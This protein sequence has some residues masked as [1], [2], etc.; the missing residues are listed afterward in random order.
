MNKKI[1][2]IIDDLDRVSSEEKMEEILSFVGEVNYDFGE[3]IRLIT[4]GSK[5]KIKKIL[6]NQ[7]EIG[8]N[9]LDKYFEK[10]LHLTEISLKKKIDFF[11]ENGRLNEK[12]NVEKFINPELMEYD[13]INDESFEEA[14]RVLNLRSGETVEE[15]YRELGMFKAKYS[16]RNIE[17]FLKDLEQEKPITEN[18]KFYNK[19]HFYLKYFYFFYPEYYSFLYEK[20]E[21]LL[22]MAERNY[23]ERDYSN[24]NYNF[25]EILLGSATNFFI[26]LLAES[27]GI[28]NERVKIIEQLEEKLLNIND[29]EDFE[30]KFYINI[31]D[32]FGIKYKI[33]EKGIILSKIIKNRKIAEFEKIELLNLFKINVSIKYKDLDELKNEMITNQVIKQGVKREFYPIRNEIMEFIDLNLIF[34]LNFNNKKQVEFNKIMSANLEEEM[35]QILF[36]IYDETAENTKSKEKLEEIIDYLVNMSIPLLNLDSLKIIE[37]LDTEKFEKNIRKL[38]DRGILDNRSLRKFMNEIDECIENALFK[39]SHKEYILNQDKLLREKVKEILEEDYLECEYYK[40]FY[41]FWILDMKKR[42]I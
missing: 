15:K 18:V 28:M 6:N 16:I 3:N 25:L 24:I 36:N 38:M 21:E 30:Y 23:H 31:V 10:L 1:V 5:S 35:K 42:N 39:N 9:F 8:E 4:L 41:Q 14:I 17:K 33:R 37:E 20:K 7:N 29:D 2:L 34:I 32:Y 22:N 11:I 13:F 26:G 27:F 40:E 19:A 12:R